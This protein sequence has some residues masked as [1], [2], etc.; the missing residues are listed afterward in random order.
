MRLLGPISP[1]ILRDSIGVTGTKLDQYTGRYRSHMA[2]TKPARDSLQ[3]A[4]RSIRQ[5]YESGD[6]TAAR[7]RR[8]AVKQQ[9]Q[10]LIERDREFEAGLKAVLSVDQQKRYAEWKEQRIRLAR[11][12]HRHG[13]RGHGGSR[14]QGGRDSAATFSDSAGS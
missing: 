13:H 1:E 5:A 2:A 7:S 9:A 12:Q 6:R 8:R 4:M 14:S 3:N 11:E 10:A